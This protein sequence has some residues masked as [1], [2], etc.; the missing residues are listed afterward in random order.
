L[1]QY[2]PFSE[3]FYENCSR[4][5]LEGTCPLANIGFLLRE[6]VGFGPLR[7]SIGFTVGRYAGCKLL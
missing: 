1:Q 3:I 5:R 2:K 6:G 4:K 7:G